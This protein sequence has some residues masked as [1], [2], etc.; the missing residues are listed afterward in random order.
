MAG[1]TVSRRQDMALRTI[2]TA[3]ALLGAAAI[4]HLYLHLRHVA[5]IGAYLLAAAGFI[6]ITIG[7]ALTFLGQH[8]HDEVAVAQKWATRR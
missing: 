1:R 7:A 6:G 3:G 4:A 5:S 8:I 2:G